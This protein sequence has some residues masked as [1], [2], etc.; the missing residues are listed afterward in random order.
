[1]FEFLK[2]KPTNT[3]HQGRH[4]QLDH[5][6]ASLVKNH[7]VSLLDA[8]RE[9]G[10]IHVLLTSLHPNTARRPQSGRHGTTRRAT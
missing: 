10:L 4:A 3:E 5:L 1:M 8:R 2:R 6:E 9:T 7:G